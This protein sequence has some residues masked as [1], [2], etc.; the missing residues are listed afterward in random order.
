MIPLGILG[1]SSRENYIVSIRTNRNNWRQYLRQ[2]NVVKIMK[3]ISTNTTSDHIFTK[4]WPALRLCPLWDTGCDVSLPQ[5]R[6]GEKTSHLFC[7]SHMFPL[8]Y[9]TYPHPFTPLVEKGNKLVH[10]SLL[11]YKHSPSSSVSL[12]FIVFFQCVAHA[13]PTKNLCVKCYVCMRRGKTRKYRQFVFVCGLACFCQRNKHNLQNSMHAHKEE[14]KRL[15]FLNKKRLI[16]QIRH[17]ILGQKTGRNGRLW[18]NYI[19]V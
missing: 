2:P 8:Q 11:H 7:Y 6:R 9:V 16:V 3:L 10:S 1:H 18:A 5:K 12:T 17:Q 19:N 14:R 4:H 13:P 15:P